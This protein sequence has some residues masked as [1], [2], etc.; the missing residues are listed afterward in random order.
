M[1]A[2]DVVVVNM[3]PEVVAVNTDLVDDNIGGVGYT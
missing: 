1:G 2:S 3:V